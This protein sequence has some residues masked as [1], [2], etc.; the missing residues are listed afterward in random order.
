MNKIHRIVWNHFRQCLVVVG[1]NA[2]ANGKTTGSIKGAGATGRVSLWHRTVAIVLMVMQALY[3]AFAAAQT[4]IRPDGRTQT[5]VGNS[6]PVYNVSTSTMSGS[7]AFNSFNAFS[8]GA[9]NTVNLI[10]PSSAANLINIVRDQRT[11]VHGILNAIKDGR[12]GGNVW[13]ANPHGFVVGAGGVVNVGSLT[14]TTPTQRFVDDFFPTPGS[15][16]PVSVAQ[17]MSGTAPRN[18]AAL[19]SILGRIN[20]A[21]AVSL[22]AGAINVAGSIYSGARFVGSAPDFIDVVNANG[23]VSASNVVVREGRIEIVADNDVSVSGTIATPGGSGVRGGDVSIRAGGNVD[24]QSGALIA[25]MATT[26]PAA[27][28]AS[29]LTTMPLRARVRWSMPLLARAAT[30][31]S[32]SSVRRKPS[33]LPVASSV[34]TAWAVARPAPY[35]SIRGTSWSA[36]TSCAAPA[37]TVLCQVAGP[38]PARISRCLPTTRSPSTKMSPSRRAP[39]PA[40]RRTTMPPVRPPLPPAT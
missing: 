2:R 33:N 39:S 31:A 14:V 38:P 21:D 25:A 13:F 35:S 36:P 24:L 20:A 16:D 22:S 11:D 15:P 4:V 10:V 12:I 37:A 34:P 40:P 1:E 7:N 23:L 27:R 18:S 26:R 32:S 19:V 5:T 17:L 29:G 3:P 9:G 6:G 30:A 8:V 28:S